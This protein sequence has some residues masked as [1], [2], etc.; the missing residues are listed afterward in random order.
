MAATAFQLTVHDEPEVNDARVVDTGLDDFNVAA[1][2]LHEVRPLACFLRDAQGA[3]I[4]GA[5]GRTWG[6]CV[7]LQQ[8]W[9]RSE[10]RRQGLGAQ[11][12]RAFEQRAAQRGCT[13]VYLETFSFQAPRLYASLGYEMRHTVAGYA[14]GIQ[15][16]WMVHVLQR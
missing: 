10:L 8:L 2:P 6:A 13:L 5:V 15:K 16:H 11:L 12:V 9:V 7:E 1:A 14:P 4:G 3:V